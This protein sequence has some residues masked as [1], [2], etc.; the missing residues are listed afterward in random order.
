MQSRGA[1]TEPS[2][3]STVKRRDNLSRE[4]VSVGM[5]DV[6]AG[7]RPVKSEPR[8]LRFIGLT[9][10]SLVLMD[11]RPRARRAQRAIAAFNG[12]SGSIGARSNSGAALALS[13]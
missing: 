2:P 6:V 7:R 10:K 1:L 12:P 8:H 13:H 3:A 11:Q 4:R 5:A 9:L